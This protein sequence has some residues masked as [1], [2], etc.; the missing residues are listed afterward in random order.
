MLQCSLASSYWC[1]T[2]VHSQ[3]EETPWECDL[4]RLIKDTQSTVGNTLRKSRNQNLQYMPTEESKW[5]KFV[6]GLGWCQIYGEAQS[7]TLQGAL[8]CS[9]NSPIW[10]FTM[11]WLRKVIWN[12]FCEMNYFDK[13]KQNN[14]SVDN[15]IWGLFENGRVALL[16][17]PGDQKSSSTPS[18][19]DNLFLNTVEEEMDSVLVSSLNE[20][21]E[22]K[23]DFC[24]RVG[25]RTSNM[26]FGIVYDDKRYRTPR[27][28]IFKLSYLLQLYICVRWC[29]EHMFNLRTS[30]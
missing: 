5:R 21:V 14:D 18:L 23:G 26:K 22:K 27:E 7:Q 8:T 11:L 20:Y 2:L 9:Q 16:V 24:L 1:V 3:T 13:K 25:E 30:C 28:S 10:L 15:M 19:I 17:N 6:K 12:S 4:L 29:K